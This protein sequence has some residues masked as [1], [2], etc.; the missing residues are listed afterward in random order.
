MPPQGNNLQKD[1]RRQA[2]ILPIFPF[3][4]PGALQSWN[5][6]WMGQLLGIARSTI[7]TLVKQSGLLQPDWG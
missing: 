5:Y 3:I 1:R 2:V 6:H 4:S 7:L